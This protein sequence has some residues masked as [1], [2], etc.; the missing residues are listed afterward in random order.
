M[1]HCTNPLY[2][3][4]II[5]SHCFIFNNPEVNKPEIQVSSK[6]LSVMHHGSTSMHVMSMGG[7]DNSLES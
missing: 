5:V 6:V 1:V 4:Y 2:Y 3:Y 7:T